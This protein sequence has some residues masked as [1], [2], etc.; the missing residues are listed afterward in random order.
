VGG[1]LGIA[2]GPPAPVS[3]VPAAEYEV[4]LNQGA[5]FTAP[6]EYVA[7]GASGEI[8]AL[9]AP[10]AVARVVGSGTSHARVQYFFRVN[11]PPGA[12]V[13]I[14]IDGRIE[15]DAGGA[16]FEEDMIWGVSA[17]LIAQAYDQVLGPGAN[18]IDNEVHSIG[19]NPTSVG[20][21]PVPLPIG[22]CPATLQG[23]PV[24]F[25]L[26]TRSNADN[27]ITLLATANNQEAFAADFEALVD[28]VISF[29]EGF[30]ATGFSIEV[31]EGVGNPVPEPAAPWLTSVGAGVLCLARRRRAPAI[32][33]S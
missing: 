10:L 28:P 13:P 30:D 7:A 32:A 3:A 23:E 12:D 8:Q 1:L 9:P 26:D 31:S 15:I 2:A 21:V 18:E 6:G 17:S 29:A 33:R 19:C 25:T 24:V 4:T 27:R 16:V 11:G 14:R 5:P 20:P 22:S